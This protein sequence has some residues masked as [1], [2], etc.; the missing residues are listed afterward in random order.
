[1]ARTGS[2]SAVRQRQLAWAKEVARVECDAAGYCAVP[3]RNLRWL[4]EEMRAQVEGGDANEFGAEG[5]PG[6][7]GALN[8][9]SAL[10]LNVF[11]YWQGKRGGDALAHALGA[12]APVAKVRFGERFPTGFGAPDV[13]ALL[14]LADGSLW[15]V[16][17]KFTEWFGHPGREPLSRQYFPAG[18]KVWAEAGLAGAQAAA[19]RHLEAPQ[20]DRLDAPQL[21]K[22]LLGLALQKGRARKKPWHLQL[23]WFR[24]PGACAREM[25]EEIARFGALLGSDRAR[26]SAITYQDLWS[27]LGP[28]VAA[29]HRDY[30]EYLSKRYFPA[31]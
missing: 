4:T 17:S 23:A 11:G 1:M 19:Q 27:K 12:P 16:E 5:K 6:K 24:E 20:F 15:A 10:A 26:F 2:E 22:H 9:S 25:D 18:K 29:A 3:E 7:I 21:L 30:A 14:E 8:S 31:E 28:A 13:D